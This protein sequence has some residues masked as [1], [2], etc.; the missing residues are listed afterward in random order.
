[1]MFALY[2]SPVRIL[3]TSRP[4]KTYM[5]VNFRACGISRGT[6]KLTRTSTVI[7]KKKK[8]RT[9]MMVG[10]GEM[11]DY[12]QVCGYLFSEPFCVHALS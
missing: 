3:Q 9:M 11:Y 7:K 12:I 5:I 10:Y 1:M 2:K 4:L 6:C 8:K